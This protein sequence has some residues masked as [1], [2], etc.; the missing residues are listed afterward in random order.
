[1]FS[2][3][4]EFHTGHTNNQV[5]C[6]Q[7][8]AQK[9]TCFHLQQHAPSIQVSLDFLHHCSVQWTRKFCFLQ[10]SLS[11]LLLSKTQNEKSVV[12]LFCLVFSSLV[13]FA[14]HRGERSTVRTNKKKLFFICFQSTGLGNNSNNLPQIKHSNQHHRQ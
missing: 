1:M 12:C 9:T 10:C 5:V 11:I 4:F 8:G 14:L 6:Q 7:K 3:I 2:T 13:L